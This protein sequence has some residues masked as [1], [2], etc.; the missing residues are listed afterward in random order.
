[1]S[2]PS[3]TQH[4]VWHT[5]RQVAAW[6]RE[7]TAQPCHGPKIGL[8]WAQF[9]GLWKAYFYLKFSFKKMK[10]SLQQIIFII[11]GT[12]FR[13]PILFLLWVMGKCGLINIIFQVYPADDTETQGFC[14]NIP[15]F[16]RYFSGRPTLGGFI[17][18]YL[19]PIGIYVVIPD[20]VTCLAQRKNSRLSHR[21]VNNLSLLSRLTGAQSNCNIVDFA[22][23]G[24]SA[25]IPN[26]LYLG[27]R[28]RRK[29]I[30]FLQSLPG[31]WHRHD[32]PACSLAFI[33]STTTTTRWT[34]IDDFSE[35][36]KKQ[37]FFVSI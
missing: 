3:S 4:V 16:R 26:K 32:I 36:A 25:N 37:G 28:V 27:N 17:T 1:M 14:P 18:Q 35:L 22:H 19:W 5:I 7:S 15:I 29:G 21:I 30:R 34:N 12:L 8:F 31:N 33:L 24:I 6:P 9:F 11:S 20:T 23:P 10:R 2:I 13:W